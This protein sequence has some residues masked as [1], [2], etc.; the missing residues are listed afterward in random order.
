[1]RVA[2]YNT[3][4]TK[5]FIE[6]TRGRAEVQTKRALSTIL[7]TGNPG[8]QIGVPQWG[9]QALHTPDE[10]YTTHFPTYLQEW[11]VPNVTLETTDT[12]RLATDGV[13]LSIHSIMVQSRCQSMMSPV[14][15]SSVIMSL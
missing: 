5:N 3:L 10:Q 4:K 9:E 1:M 13:R 7:A 15:L 2:S 8:F 14:T 6:N 11:F 12:Q